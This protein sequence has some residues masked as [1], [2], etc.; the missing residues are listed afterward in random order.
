M[1]VD[2]ILDTLNRQEVEYLLIGGMNFFIRHRPVSTFDVDVWIAD[3][4]VNRSRCE[5]A[6]RELDASWGAE[7]SEWG[8]V[9]R[10]GQ[11]WLERHGVYCLTSP[12]GDIDIFRSVRGLPDWSTCGRRAVSLTTGSGVPFLGLSDQDMLTCQLALPEGQQRV[13]RVQFLRKVLHDDA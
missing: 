7:E 13:D 8:P 1:N 9:A 11:G 3:T 2:H 10:L 5:A 12:S 6:L 4:P